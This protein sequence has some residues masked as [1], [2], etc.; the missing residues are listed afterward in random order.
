MNIQEYISSGIIESYILGLANEKETN[1]FERLCMHHPELVSARI[2]FEEK[3]EAYVRENAIDPPAY[4]RLKTSEA[5]RPFTRDNSSKI[6]SIQSTTK[7]AHSGN[8]LLKYMIAAAVILLIGSAY[9]L[10]RFQAQNERIKT[11]NQALLAKVNA[12]DS[13]L[14]EIVGEDQLMKGSNMKIVKMEGTSTA[15]QASASIYWDSTSESVYLVVKNMPKLPDGKQY[16]LWAS[17]DNKPRNLG[18]FN[19]TDD[20]VVI[21][22]MKNIRKADAFAITI[23][24][25]GGNITPSLDKTQATGKTKPL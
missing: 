15:P 25:K 12:K 21:L 20:K 1:E 8:R 14:R 23:E 22:K 16:Q 2:S 6:V 4:V 10:N 11:A 9:L 19:A 18:V 13:L 17:V 24:N 5:I 3:L 7:A